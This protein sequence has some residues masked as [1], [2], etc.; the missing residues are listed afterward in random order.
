MQFVFF[1]VVGDWREIKLEV[2]ALSEVEEVKLVI[3][4]RVGCGTLVSVGEK[5]E[6][7]ADNVDG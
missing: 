5:T 2:D 3:D 1:E 4:G 6:M 7:L